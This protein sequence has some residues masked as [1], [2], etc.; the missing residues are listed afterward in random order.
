MAPNL[1]SNN[2]QPMD[3]NVQSGLDHNISLESF[4]STNLL[5]VSSLSSV[6]NTSGLSRE[7]DRND[8]DEFFSLRAECAGNLLISFLNINSLRNKIT[9]LRMI[10]ERCLPD[11]LLIEETKLN[12]DFETESFLINNYKSPIRLD[13][14]EFGGGLMQ[15][16]RS[17]IICNRLPNFEVPSLELLCSELVVAKKKWIVFST[18]RPPNASIETFLSDLSTS[19]N[20][21]LD[22]YDN[23]IVMG[24]INIDTQNKTDPG[25]DKLASFCDVFGLSNLVTSKTCFTKN[26]SSSIDV[27]LTN[28]PRSFQKTSVFE[29]GLSDY[30]GL[31]ASTMKS[32]VPRLKPKQIKDRSYKKFVP[33]NFLSDVKH[34]QFECDGA[35]P[36]KSYDHLT[37]TFRNIVDKHAPIKTKFLRGNDA[38]FMNPELRKAMYTRARLKRRL[39]KHPS[40]QN[41]IAFKKQRNRC[42]SLRKKAIKNHFKRV[43]S[44]GLMSNKAFWD[45]VKPFLSNKGVLAGTDISLVKDDKIVTDDHDLCEIFNDYYINIVE[46]TSGKKPSSIANAN[47]VDDD[48]EIVRLILD[49]YKDHPSILAIV[50][51]PEHTFQSF[52]FNEVTARDVWLQL[53]ML[54]GS[55]STGVDQIPPKLVSLASDDL[56]V[57]LTNAI[58]CSIRNFIFPQNAKTAAVCPLDKGEPIRTVERNYRPVS[59]LNTFS[60]I[61][62][63]ILKEQL[64]PFLDKTLSIFIAAYRTAYST[65]HVLIKLVEEWKS[66][67]DN[68]FIVGSVLM[69]LSKAFDCI[70]HD[71]IIAKLHAYGFDENALVLVYSYLK[72]RKQSIRINNVYSSFQEIVSGVPQGSVLGPILFN[73]YINDL[74]SFIKQATMY[75]YADDNTLAFFSKSLPDLVKVLE[76]EADS[77]LSWLEQN[78]MTANPN[79]FHALFVKKDQTNTCGINLDFQGHS[80]KSEETVKLLGVTLDYKLKFDPHIS[81]LCKKAAAQLNVLKRLKSFIGF[82]EKEVLVQSFV[83]S[84]FNYC[85][86]VWYFS[87]SKSLQKIERIQ[88][89]ALRFCTMIVKVPIMIFLLGQRSAQCKLL[90]R[91]PSVSKYSRQSKI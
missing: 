8:I 49:K 50:Q 62:E 58:N 47:L 75:N 6:N 52:S 38:P 26:H 66:K 74:F 44:N 71:L 5:S 91:E 42:V 64:S 9:D 87:S 12:S 78:E 33:E 65:Q 7:S 84:N 11:V 70:P 4:S 56:A 1:L 88:E 19:L 37:N 51:D 79:K 21:A 69:D 90:V 15:Y 32:T 53:K 89:R 22:R 29:I 55:K 24:N 30:H 77:A 43:T 25:F 14:S 2:E 61:F 36:D 82:A 20:R 13:R 83:Y 57:P 40:K 3:I 18:Y 10:A 68:N 45:L 28:R 80:I 17:G 85:P 46:S 67:L 76:N 73:F 34:A 27:I 63:K 16:S 54:D 48:R 23:V 31:V 59:I 41:E 35:N 60:K 81:N 39:N 86:L 72:Q